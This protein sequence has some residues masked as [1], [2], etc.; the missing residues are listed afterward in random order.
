VNADNQLTALN[1]KRKV[2]WFEVPIADS[3][4]QTYR[5]FEF[6]RSLPDAMDG[7]LGRGTMSVLHR[8]TA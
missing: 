1:P 2:Q 8:P 5:R 4:V 6:Q 3:V 7:L